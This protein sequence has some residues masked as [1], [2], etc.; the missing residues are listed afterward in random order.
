MSKGTVNKVI[1]LG[2]LGQ[3]PEVRTAAS[4]TK[5]VNLNV[6]TNHGVRDAQ[7]NWSDA[8]EWHR[9]TLFGKTADA[10]AQYLSKGSSVYLEGRLQT[11][12]WQDQQGQDRYTTEIVCNEMQF[13]GGR[14]NQGGG[15]YPAGN[16][17]WGSAPAAQP[18]QTH[19][20]QPAAAPQQAY[21]QP[22]AQPP[23]GYQQ[24]PAQQAPQ[25]A[26]PQQAPRP[27]APQAAPQPRLA[28]QP[29]PAAQQAAWQQPQQAAPS[30]QPNGGFNDEI[31]DDDIP[32]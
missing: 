22:A 17:A 27:A 20:Q 23:Q 7:G 8:T 16:D 18:Q 4:G 26:A 5:I 12:K 31:F 30:V 21:Q 24:P 32:F 11:R 3:D 10:A 6:A 13:I 25:Q 28:Q 1:I 29:S 19:Y 9:C 14:D 15:Q 2:R